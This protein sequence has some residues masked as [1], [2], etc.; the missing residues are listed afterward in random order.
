MGCKAHEEFPVNPIDRVFA[1]LEGLG[2]QYN[3]VT[4]AV[5]VL[6]LYLILIRWTA[7]RRF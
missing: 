4:L 6:L 3:S 2:L 7:T 5:G 1:L